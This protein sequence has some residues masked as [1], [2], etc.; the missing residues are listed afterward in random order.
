MIQILILKK[1]FQWFQLLQIPAAILFGMMID[2]CP[3][4]YKFDFSC[5]LCGKMGA[6]HRRHSAGGAWRFAGS[7]GQFNHD[8]R[9][10]NLKFG[11]MKVVFDV[12]LVLISVVVSFIFLG[13]LEGLREGTLVSA[14]F[15]GQA[16]KV[17]SRLLL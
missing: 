4:F 6:L 1:N 13:S 14:V 9:F 11:T 7:Q 8:S 2:V 17:F 15:A 16:A 10:P 5:K 3:S 12:T